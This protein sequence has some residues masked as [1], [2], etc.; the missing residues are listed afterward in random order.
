[1]LRRGSR[2]ACFSA[3]GRNG[4]NV[5][6]DRCLGRSVSRERWKSEM[7]GCMAARLRALCG[8]AARRWS[9]GLVVGAAWQLELKIIVHVHVYIEDKE[10]MQFKIP[11]IFSTTLSIKT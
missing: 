3:R 1:M 5:V 11:F 6:E 8:T 10:R 4:R 9:C 2:T 7:Y